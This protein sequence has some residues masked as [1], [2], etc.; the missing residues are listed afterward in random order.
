MVP[1]KG[2]GHC[3]C[4]SLEAA[5]GHGWGQGKVTPKAPAWQLQGKCA[6]WGRMGGALSQGSDVILGTA[7]RSGRQGGV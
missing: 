5:L 2:G 7:G 6:E 4:E 1:R 3:V